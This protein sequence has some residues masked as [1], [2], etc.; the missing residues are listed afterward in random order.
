M[1][2]MPATSHKIIIG[3]G[4]Y[5]EHV[6]N[7][8]RNSFPEISI[9][10]IIIPQ[11]QNYSFDFGVLDSFSPANITAFIAFDER[12]GNFKR[13]ELIHETRQRGFRL[14]PFLHTKAYIAEDVIIGENV[15]IDANTT[16]G[17]GC[18]I[19]YNTVIHAG[20]H[21]SPGCLI[22]H[23]C[24]V[25]GGVTFGSHVQIGTHGIVRS[26]S[27]VASGIKIGNSCELGWP[28]AYQADIASK[29]IFDP[30]YD[31][32]IHVYEFRE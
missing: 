30:R 17:H 20:A 7:S 28:Q 31:N 6:Y 9:E 16:I 15:F 24:W 2:R 11:T 14:E 18:H 27:I 1:N 12:F 4:A 8:W 23:S 3:S 13:L 26:G 21:I 22:G 19:E 29:T 25:E 32:P 5:L 10:K